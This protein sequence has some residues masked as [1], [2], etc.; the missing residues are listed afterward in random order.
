MSLSHENNERGEG[1]GGENGTEERSMILAG[2]SAPH[3]APP[4]GRGRKRP[5]PSLSR[6]AVVRFLESIRPH[7]EW[8]EEVRRQLTLDYERSCRQ[9][10]R[11]KKVLKKNYVK[12]EIVM[13]PG[14]PQ[15]R[16]LDLARQLEARLNQVRQFLEGERP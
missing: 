16:C 11:I 1:K 3:P 9:Q 6:E 10:I 8:L 13:R 2:F 4:R 7:V 5:Q 14:Q 12:L 15:E